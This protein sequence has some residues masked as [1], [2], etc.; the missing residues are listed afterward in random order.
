MVVLLGLVVVGLVII[1]FSVGGVLRSAR[2]RAADFAERRVPMSTPARGVTTKPCRCPALP[3][4]PEHSSQ[5]GSDA[6][7]TTVMGTKSIRFWTMRRGRGSVCRR[8]RGRG[9]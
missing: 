2:D 8:V 9:G 7:V 1:G 4:A 5:K 3:S 6:A